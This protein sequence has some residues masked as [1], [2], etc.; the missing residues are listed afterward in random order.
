MP[1]ASEITLAIGQLLE[2]GVRKQ[3]LPTRLEDRPADD[4]LTVAWPMDS[5]RR[6]QLLETGDAVQLG[7]VIRGDG[8]YAAE[9][10]V[11]S[12]NRG[13][14]S[15]VTVGLEGEWQRSQRRNAVRVPVAIR[16]R[17]AE[18]IYGEKARRPVRLGVTDISATG[19][20]VRS[21]DEIR[22]GDLLHLAFELEGE[23]NLQA[24][25]RR[26]ACSERVWDGGCAFEGV[27]EAEAE[28]IVRF[29][30]AQQRAALR[31]K[32]GN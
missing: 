19:V 13:N 11:V 7:V 6:P 9:A 24:R 1:R 10:K 3:W 26:V 18:V 28:R 14:V 5:L 2:I 21:I 8:A 4:Q 32:R 20:H 22:A 23:V 16:P 30:F 17:V 15:L 12:L 25:V 29:I 31:A 27:S